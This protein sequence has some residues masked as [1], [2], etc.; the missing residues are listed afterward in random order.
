MMPLRMAG[1]QNIRAEFN[2]SGS[3][4]RN[5]LVLLRWAAVLG[6]GLTLCIV[7]FILKFDYPFLACSAIVC[8][9]ALVNIAVSAALPLDRRASN[10]EVALH[11][12]FDIWQLSLLLWFTGGM[13]NPFSILFLAP[14][15]TAATTLSRAVLFSLASFTLILS[16][17]LLFNYQPLPWAAGES[18]APPFTY[19]IA[20]WISITVGAGFTSL[21]A[22]RAS[23]ESRKMASALAATESMLAQ[24]QK[25]SALG[26]LA[27]A[28]A[29]ELGTPLATIQVTA[30]EMTRE[31]PQDSALGEDAR[32]V[33]SQTQRCR[34]I[35]EQ[36]SMRGDQG[37]VM[38]D[39][40]SVEDLLEEAAEPFIDR[41]KDISIHVVPDNFD[42]KPQSGAAQSS[43]KNNAQNSEYHSDFGDDFALR[44]Q[45]ELIYGLK[46][47]IENAV[48]FA[49]NK[50]EL[51]AYWDANRLHI[52]ID[53]DGR[54]FDAAVK[55]KLGQPYVTRRR[56]ESKAGGLGLG[57]FIASTLI[58]RTNG[59]VQFLQSPLGGARVALSWPRKA[60]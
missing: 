45:P 5:T 54:G 39:R 50:V 41:G 53:D 21:Y 3:L 51:S 8:F 28:A 57:I 56:K 15:V 9:T 6:Q 11:L 12:G 55:N 48:D 22:W 14:I 46:N 40:L 47:Y 13:I 49:R 36:L 16:L 52:I 60:L 33:L 32:L 30:K 26:G 17:G 20:F 25:L 34:A 29:H 43:D 35:L 37:D 4:R 2:L 58:E 27:A 23:K 44:R 24:E 10:L 42:Y 19:R 59:R 38:H 31:L 1:H 7:S 18:F